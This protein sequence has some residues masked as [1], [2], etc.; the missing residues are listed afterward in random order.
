MPVITTFYQLNYSN[1]TGQSPLETVCLMPAV[2]PTGYE[3]HLIVND[4]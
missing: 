4:I 3:V 1:I 2:T